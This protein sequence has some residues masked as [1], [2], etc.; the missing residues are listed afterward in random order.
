MA[1]AGAISL[2]ASSHNASPFGLCGR[3][4][5]IAAIVRGLL[6]AKTRAVVA[7]G[8]AGIGKSVVAAAALQRVAASGA[9][10]G[11][12]QHGI[13]ANGDDLGPFLSALEQAVGAGL[14]LLYDPEAGF[15]ML[16]RALGANARLL[17]QD[18]AG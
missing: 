8:V 6:D 1:A 10:T 16:T 14:D 18:G 7:V 3:D 2:M 12:S 17:A 15:G 5:E 11:R 9:L 13:G 4:E